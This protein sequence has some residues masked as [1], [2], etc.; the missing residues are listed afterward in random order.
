[1]PKPVSLSDS[2]MASSCRLS[3]LAMPLVSP[4]LDDETARA[5]DYLNPRARKKFR[6]RANGARV[7]DREAAEHSSACFGCS[8]RGRAWQS[9]QFLIVRKEYLKYGTRRLSPV[10]G[11]AAHM[12]HAAVLED[13]LVAHPQAEAGAGVLL[14]GEER[15]KHPLAH[16]LFHTVAGIRDRETHPGDAGELPAA[17][18]ACPHHQATPGGGGIDG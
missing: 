7:P 2:A 5:V 18:A 6:S 15:F 12:H 11:G 16:F 10:A 13:D 9:D 4:D 3:P 17:G 1:M 14:G 8:G